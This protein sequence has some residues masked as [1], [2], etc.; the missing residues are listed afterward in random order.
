MILPAVRVKNPKSERSGVIGN[1]FTDAHFPSKRVQSNGPR[2]FRLPEQRSAKSFRTVQAPRGVFR[3]GRKPLN[4]ALIFE[5]F[6]S[7]RLI[8]ENHLI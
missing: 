6:A 4:L 7:S 8:S 2:C 1:L 3:S 5:V